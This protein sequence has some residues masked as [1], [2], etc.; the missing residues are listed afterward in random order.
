MGME[1]ER[2]RARVKELRAAS[3]AVHGGERPERPAF[4]PVVTPIYPGS[5]YIYDDLELMDA[6]LA[7][8]EG[9]YVYTRYGNP[10]TTALEAVI[11]DLEGTT[12]AVSFS[13][14]MAALHAAIMTSVQPG[15]AIV[16]SQDLYGATYAMLTGFMR[17]WG[18]AVE[19]VD[20]LDL[21]AVGAAIERSR[22][23]LIVCEVISNP[24]LRVMDLPAVVALAKPVRAAVLVDSTFCSPVLYAP[25]A[26]GAQLVVHSLTKYISGHGDVTGGIVATTSLRRERLSNFAKMAGAILGPFE[27][28]LSLRGV[29]TLPLR[30]RRQCDN[31]AVVAAALAEHPRVARV[32]FPGLASH[33][34]HATAKRLFGERGYGGMVSFELRAGGREQAFVFLEALRMVVPATSL[35]DVYSL[36]LY[37]AMSSHRNL[38]PEERDAVGISDGLLRLSIGIEDPADIVADLDQALEAAARQ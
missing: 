27:A 34:S 30:M 1:I 24:L 38:S 36:A 3:R 14:G 8:A 5:T 16:A 4:T 31:A 17:E 20:M 29:K 19:F 32:N 22:P 15:D 9:R 6:A 25:A 21:D 13:S 35:G 18:C 7:G 26:D 37:P 12:A 23:A 28:W 2:A 11:A 33:P 10:T